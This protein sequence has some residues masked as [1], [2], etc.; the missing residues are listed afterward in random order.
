[1]A[2]ILNENTGRSYLKGT[3]LVKY[4]IIFAT[5][6]DMKDLFDTSTSFIHSF[7]CQINEWMKELING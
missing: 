6:H 2:S 3:F 7:I 1:M 5:R 4:P